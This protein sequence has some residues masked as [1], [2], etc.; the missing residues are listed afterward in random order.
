[1]LKRIIIFIIVL[2]ILLLTACQRDY[3]SPLGPEITSSENSSISI[4]D[5]AACSSSYKN[6]RIQKST[7]QRHEFLKVTIDYLNPLSYTSNS[8]PV[9]Y[10]G[11]IFSYRIV[12][13]N[14]SR[15]K[16]F[17]NLKVRVTHEYA[18]PEADPD[19]WL[20]AEALAGESSIELN[21]VTIGPGAK[22]VFT[23]S[24]YPVSQCGNGLCRTHVEIFRE[25]ARPGFH[26][27]M[28]KQNEDK[29]TGWNTDKKFRWFNDPEA[30]VFYL[31]QAE[32]RDERK[33]E[34]EKRKSEERS[35]A[36]RAPADPSPA[37]EPESN[38]IAE[39]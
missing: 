39:K 25:P 19:P 28:K 34:E 26:A 20:Q 1:M 30:G 24:F 8:V 12:I 29:K 3:I 16:K 35:E 21:D 5:P 36:A 7:K 23:I 14:L 17:K 11:H 22:A 38:P 10:I 2:S 15:T 6:G 9:Y 27:N 33:K 37:P 31:K 32:L 18:G 13:Q 4:D